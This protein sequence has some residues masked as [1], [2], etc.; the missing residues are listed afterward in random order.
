MIRLSI[1]PCVISV[2]KCSPSYYTTKT[3]TWFYK[4][5]K[6]LETCQTFEDFHWARKSSK[7]DKPAKHHLPGL[8][9]VLTLS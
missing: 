9:T 3:K 5:L 6:G 8:E 4:D 1:G 7:E 2:L